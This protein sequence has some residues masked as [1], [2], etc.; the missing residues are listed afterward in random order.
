M[1][2]D[3]YTAPRLA[4]VYDALNPPG[5]DTAFYLDLA[6]MR[7]RTVLDMGCGTG[8]LA[9]ELAARGHDV[10][11]ADPAGAMLDLARR[12]SGGDR[13]AWVRSDAAALNLGARFDLIV[14]TGHVFQV[15]LDDA[16]TL[17]SL[18]C[19]RRHLAPGGR[20]AFE[21]R[22]PAAREWQDWTEAGTA[23]RVE[24]SGLQVAVHYQVTDVAGEI[25]TYET[26]FDFAADDRHVTIGRLRFID[27][28][29]LERLLTQA[30]FVDLTW[31]GDW[32]RSPPTATSPEIIVIAG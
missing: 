12:R 7:P 10:T 24:V 17:A 11:G 3:S 5:A 27:R 28:D 8:W 20:L 32:D 21:T 14:M 4:A 13:V 15:F 22:N 25:V 19:L 16:T 30:G 9:A 2:C 18:R 23:R 1:T 31:Y 6:G 29:S 26:R